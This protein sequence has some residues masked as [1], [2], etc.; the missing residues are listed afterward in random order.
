M[1][2]GRACL[3]NPLLMADAQ[4]RLTRKLNVSPD[5]SIY[6]TK[7]VA[8]PTVSRLIP[9]QRFILHQVP[10]CLSCILTTHFEYRGDQSEETPSEVTE[11]RRRRVQCRR[12]STS[13]VR[14][15][16][17]MY[18]MFLARR[19][20]R[21]RDVSHPATLILRETGAEEGNRQAGKH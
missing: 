4:E 11:L 5:F 6:A 21:E 10:A 2:S 3:T 17:A 13:S 9:P 15:R 18:K 7:Y 1:A 14:M 19:K 20:R 16:A 8:S 12:R